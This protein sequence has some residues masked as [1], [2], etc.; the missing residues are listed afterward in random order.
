MAKPCEWFRGEAMAA[1]ELETQ[2]LS[3]P[4]TV[5]VASMQELRVASMQDWTASTTPRMKT[6]CLASVTTADHNRGVVDFGVRPIQGDLNHRRREAC[7]L[8]RQL[9]GDQGCIGYDVCWDPS[10]E[11]EFHG[12][13][14][15]AEREGLASR[16]I[17]PFE[18]SLTEGAVE[19]GQQVLRR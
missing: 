3:F 12:A 14:E 4:E 2:S 1:S 10:C 18:G 13:K 7:Q 6:L 15:A 19:Q 17:H 11:A 8:L 9:G 16:E 5:R